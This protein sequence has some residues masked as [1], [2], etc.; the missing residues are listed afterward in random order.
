MKNFR[1]YKAETVFTME[2]SSSSNQKK[3]NIAEIKNGTKNLKVLK[4]AMI[5]GPN[6]SGKSNLI[7]AV[8]EIC[9]LI[10][11][12]QKL[13][14]PIS[15]CDPFLFEI[16]TR[17]KSTEF[18][19]CFVG[20]RNIRFVYQFSIKNNIVI[21]E[22][23][24]SY[25]GKKNLISRHPYNSQLQSQKGIIEKNKEVSVFANQL[26]L[27]RFGYDEPHELLSEVFSYFTNYIIINAVNSSHTE[28]IN[29]ITNNQLY[30]N[31]SQRK[32]LAKLIEE[33][34]TQIKDI[35]ITKLNEDDYPNLPELS[36]QA[37]KQNP[38]IV[39]G[40]HNLFMGDKIISSLE[41]PFSQ[42]SDGTKTLYNL[43]GSVLKVLDDGGV[44]VVDELDSSLHPFVTKMLV[45]LFH[46]PKINPKNA[47]LIFT[48][49]DVTLLDKDLIRR[50]QVWIAEK[51]KSGATELFSLQD[52]E[53]LREDTPF[54]KWYLAGKFG[55]L[56]KIKSIDSIFESNA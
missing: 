49:H 14:D 38:F 17:D 47:Q 12:K 16:A 42:E 22:N 11:I 15:I 1:S 13:N 44:L 4:S 31:E 28:K 56:P 26:I 33:A 27:S 8:F 23:L 10:L 25:P 7:Q 32:R 46:S 35:K 48:T 53:G 30:N 43:G 9:K 52:F 54:E 19:I 29:G 55:G 45:S 36:K 2:A 21:T 50:D 40:V 41:L 5:Y 24:D 39:Y 3:S 6:A 51:D 37:L 18:E 20:P 34:D